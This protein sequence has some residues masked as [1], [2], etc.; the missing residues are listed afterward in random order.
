MQGIALEVECWYLCI[1][2][3]DNKC[4]EKNTCAEESFLLFTKGHISVK[5]RGESFGYDISMFEL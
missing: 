5:R 3:G 1:F 4:N 2:N